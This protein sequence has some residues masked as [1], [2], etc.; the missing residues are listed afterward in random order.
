MH[1]WPFIVLMLRVVCTWLLF[2]L[3]S[4]NNNYEEGTTTAVLEQLWDKL[5]QHLHNQQKQ[6]HDIHP[7]PVSRQKTTMH[8]RHLATRGSSA[9]RRRS[10]LFE[11]A[12]NDHY[13]SSNSHIAATYLY[14]PTVAFEPDR[15]DSLFE[16]FPPFPA[17]RTRH[18][19]DLLQNMFAHSYDSYMTHAWPAAEVKPISCQGTRFELV[20][21]AGLTLFDSLDTLLVL[22]NYTEFARSVERLRNYERETGF[23]NVNENVSVFETTIRVLGGLL[24]AHQ[25]AEAFVSKQV[26]YAAVFDTDQQVRW[27]YNTVE[28]ATTSVDTCSMALFHVE[29]QVDTSMIL[30]ECNVVEQNQKP[31]NA[32]K[33]KYWNYDGFLLDLARDLGNRLYPAFNSKTGI[34]YGTVNL[35]HGVPRGET[36]I[37]SLAGAGTLSLEFELLSRLTGEEKFGKAAKLASRALWM[38][39]SKKGLNLFG[40]HID[41]QKGQ[42]TETLSGIGSNSDSFIEYLAKHYF[43]FPEDEDFW[44]LFMVAYSGVFEHSRLGEWYVDTDMN[45]GAR[46]GRSKHVLES[47]MAF[48]PGMQVLLGELTPASRSLNSFFM[49]RELLG[50]LPERFN[51]GSWQVDAGRGRAGI[52]PLR[53]ELLESNYFLHRATQGMSAH[54]NIL[55]SGWQWAA[56]FAI[57]KIEKVSRHECGYAGME[58]VHP[59][60]TGIVDGSVNSSLITFIDEMPSFFLSETIKYLYLTFDEYNIL[61]TDDDHQWTFTTEAHPIHSPLKT[62]RAEEIGALKSLLLHKIQGTEPRT[63]AWRKSYLGHEKWSDQTS[64]VA[65]HT[66][67]FQCRGNMAAGNRSGEGF[68]QERQ[69]EGSF[70][71][72][73]NLDAFNDSVPGNNFVHTATKSMGTGTDLRKS[74]PNFYESSLLWLHALT[75]G[76]QDYTSSY[77]SVTSDDLNGHPIHFVAIGAADALG[78]H[79]AGLHPVRSKMNTTCPIHLQNQQKADHSD[80]SGT[81]R[82]DGGQS[83]IN[84]GDFQVRKVR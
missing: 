10:L 75:G 65:F 2:A 39:R 17:S 45:S 62:N 71:N 36:T 41:I 49:V 64:H 83:A 23:F 76:S 61:H 59:Q 1:F 7:T 22:G 47:L 44:I 20:P 11:A 53:P 74:C 19:L 68:F 26:Q 37:A 33:L 60:T 21:L 32:T 55:S 12:V 9:Q 25:M 3:V 79:G 13:D 35:L 38:R 63:P 30:E 6:K 28:A 51:F 43:L 50:F 18:N 46:A 67:S 5:S 52:H 8:T 58:N 72:R 77:V 31:F 24:S 73:L 16:A 82:L 81:P 66:D 56:D 34:P 42:W 54:G 27:G 69:L 15:T 78:I 4:S 57:H 29:H 40:K 84:V 14:A 48:Y 70:V 80:S